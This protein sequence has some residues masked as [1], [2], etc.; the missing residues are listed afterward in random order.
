MKLFFF[1]LSLALFSLKA[2]AQRDVETYLGQAQRSIDEQDYA[3]GIK[4]INKALEY[5]NDVN[6]SYKVAR[7][8]L[9]RGFCKFHLKK[10]QEAEK[11]FDQAIQ[12]SPEFLK[13]FEAKNLVYFTTRQFDAM[14]ANS[15]KALALSPNNTKF[16]LS[17]AMASL[18]TFDYPKALQIADSV[19]ELKEDDL[20]ALHLKAN[21]LYTQKKYEEALEVD[22]HI[23]T[24]KPNDSQTLLS[25]GILYAKMGQYDKSEQDNELASRTDSSFRYVA[26]NNTAFF[27]KMNNKDYPGALT[28]LDKCVSLK[29]DFAYAYSNISYCKLQLGDIPGALKS[30]QKSLE[31]DPHNSYAYKNYALIR[32]RQ[33]K[34]ADA[35][36]LLKIAE[37][38]GYSK[39]YDDEVSQLLKTSCN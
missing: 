29:P 6:N 28:L 38:K 23:L 31:L 5:K 37:D 4:H 12:V 39:Q 33:Q 10:Y 7:L 21:V 24:L 32:L 22:N 17:S 11:D 36:K 2:E 14:I 35:C 8:Y 20:D 26:C 1:L 16:M 27:I 13:A 30:V 18:Q 34:N 25:R 15:A 3:G 19:L 9:T